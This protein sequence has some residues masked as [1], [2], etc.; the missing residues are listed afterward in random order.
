MV[1]HSENGRLTDNELRL[2][3]SFVIHGMISSHDQHTLDP[4]TCPLLTECHLQDG[5]LDGF[6]SDLSTQQV[7]LAMGYL[8]VCRRIF[9][10]TG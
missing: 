6:P 7:E 4:I 9:M 3:Q 1:D 5:V 8:K 10:L 2:F